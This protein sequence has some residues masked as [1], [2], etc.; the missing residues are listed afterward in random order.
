MYWGFSVYFCFAEGEWFGTEVVGVSNFPF[1]VI[2]IWRL[3]AISG[4]SK[5]VLYILLG[6]LLPIVALLIGTDIY[7]YSRP[8]AFSGGLYFIKL[9]AV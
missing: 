3:Y 9:A 2:L 5:R 1:A 6:L 7:L 4:Q 8:S